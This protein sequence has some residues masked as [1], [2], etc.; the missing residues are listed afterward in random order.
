MANSRL[1]VVARAFVPQALVAPQ[2]DLAFA[3]R[4]LAVVG[5]QTWVRS[6]EQVVRM[7]FA[8]RHCHRV[9]M[10]RVFLNHRAEL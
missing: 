6:A 7:A 10:K 2:F 5:R 9:L 3:A 8:P 1:G 4:R